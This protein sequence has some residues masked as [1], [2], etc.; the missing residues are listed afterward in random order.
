V[1]RFR[2]PGVRKATGLAGRLFIRLFG[3]LPLPWCRR[4]GRAMGTAGYYLI[5]RIRRVAGQN[6]GLVYGDTLSVAEKRAMALGASRSIA[7][8]G[9]EFAHLDKIDR[10]FIEKHCVV[11]GFDEHMPT[12]GG[13]LL[14]GAHFGNW[15][16]LAPIVQ[17]LC[18]QKVCGIVRP[19]DDPGLDRAVKRL[20]MAVGVDIIS[21]E[22]AGAEIIR[23]LRE[24]QIVGVL[25]DQSPRESA[26]PV[27]FMGQPA[28]ATVAPVMAAFR[29][30]VPVIPFSCVR[31]DSGDYAFTF[32]PPVPISRT[33]DLQRDILDNT[34]RCQD[35]IV[36][37]IQTHPD[38]WLWMHR[39]W[40]ER[41]RLEKEWARRGK[42]S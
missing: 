1:A 28:W 29:A 31:M 21:K 18:P 34:Q 30:H 42:R 36:E 40:K 5:P 8:T 24:G 26:A 20:R 39:R 33:G 2:I 6:I 11:R 7:I 3:A 25:I 38:Q 9:A 15:E 35:A 32:H 14:V 16:W 37:T 17:T 23:R 22:G 10:A 27:S 13:V 19:L 12:E 41:P 4:I